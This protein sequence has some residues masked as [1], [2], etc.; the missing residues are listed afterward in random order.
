MA[1]EDEFLTH[2]MKFETA[3]FPF[4]GS[5]MSRRY[6]N[7]DDWMGLLRRFAE[8]T[9]YPF[10]RYR[11]DA[12]RDTGRMASAI[13]ERFNPVWW[14][15]ELYSSSRPAFPDPESRQSP[16][17]IETGQY[18]FGEGCED[19]EHESTTR[20]GGVDVLLQGFELD[21]LLQRVHVVNQVSYGSVEPVESPN[22]QNVT[23]ANL[24]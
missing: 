18:L 8:K 5:G 13:A 19:I 2:L 6:L 9:D 24:V 10:E 20:G 12:S 3:P 1:I 16:L 14:E 11:A 17:K 7:T 4:V 23:G 21:A 15:S 22:H